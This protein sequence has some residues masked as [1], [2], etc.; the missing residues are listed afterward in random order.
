MKKPKDKFQ[1][2]TH[3]ELVR[4]AMDSSANN[5]YLQKELEAV[6]ARYAADLAELSKKNERLKSVLVEAKDEI[7]VMEFMIS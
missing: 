1:D 7:G 5:I 6:K 3:A 2:F 4:F